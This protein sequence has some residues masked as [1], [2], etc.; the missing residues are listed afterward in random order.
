MPR[1]NDGTELLKRL[2][3]LQVFRQVSGGGNTTLAATLTAGATAVNLTASTSF[4]ANDPIFLQGAGGF[5]LNA[6]TATT[7]TTAV[8]LLYKAAFGQPAGARVIEA[9]A[10][11]LA[12]ITE[13]GLSWSAS[14]NLTDVFSALQSGAIARIFGQGTQEVGFSLLGFNGLNLQTWLGMPEAETGAGSSADPYQVALGG[15]T[16]GTQ[17]LQCIRATGTRFD[18]S[19]VQ[20]D[21]NDAV[22]IPSGAVTMNRSAAAALPCT[23]RFSDAVV[24]IWS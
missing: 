19:T 10:S 3:T 8:P 14:A 7:P 4:T 5:E 2:D 18:G 15:S 13:D 22:L 6:I 20:L 24:R 21:F 16:M 23:L 11:N 12:H 1:K 17:G 9:V